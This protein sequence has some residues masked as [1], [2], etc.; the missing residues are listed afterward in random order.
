[1]ESAFLFVYGAL[2]R[3]CELH[4]HM[5]RASFSGEG[6]T[7]GRLF[8]FGQYAGL[9]DGEGRVRGELYRFDDLPAALDILDDVEDYNP[10]EPERSLY[11][12]V[13]RPVR[14]D[15]GRTV[16]AWVYV[17]NGSTA[18]AAQIEGGDWRASV[19]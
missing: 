16:D 5:E 11:V 19:R 13:V 1:L 18:G 2:M 6:S 4:H 9:V 7:R 14:M 10:A 12:R 17:F 8:S 15:D 3:G